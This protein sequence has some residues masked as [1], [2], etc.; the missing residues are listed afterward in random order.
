MYGYEG[1]G[2]IYWHQVSKLLLAIQEVATRAIHQNEAADVV[3]NL[4]RAYYRVRSGL[5]FEKTV[6]EYGAFPTDPYSHTP[7]H[8]GAQ[9]PGMTG[10]VKEEILTRFG[11]LGVQV[12]EGAVSFNP[13][14][15]RR[16]EFLEAPAIYRFYD[17]RGK[18]RTLDV[19]AGALAFSFCQV[20]V[21]YRL[22]T[23]ESWIQVARVN[24]ES[25]ENPGNRL[26]SLS[27]QDLFNRLGGISLIEVG[28]PEQSLCRI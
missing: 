12:E 18:A 16:E 11:E 20:P 7:A 25:R 3:E 23:D 9:Q 5:S 17:L 8:A 2:C 21:I 26:D 14:I 4:I 1:L 22:T 28:V 15:L 6:V 13:V 19:P 10:Q 24:G 27:S